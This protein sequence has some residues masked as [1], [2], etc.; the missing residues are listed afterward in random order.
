MLKK[1]LVGVALAV[2]AMI[3]APAAAGALGYTDQNGTAAQTVSG[4]VVSMTFTGFPPNTPA[5]A[6]APDAVTLSMLKATSLSRPT[7]AD[8][9]VVFGASATQPGTYTI[10]VTAG[11][12][13]ATGTLTVVPVDSAAGDGPGA[14]AEDGIPGTGYDAPW[15][16]VWIGGGALLLGAALVVALNASRR[17]RARG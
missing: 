15:Q 9:A 17:A 8:G 10:T 13:V 5:T 11:G 6:S 1:F 2:A 7:D 16:W 12:L 3:S 14:G 4:Q